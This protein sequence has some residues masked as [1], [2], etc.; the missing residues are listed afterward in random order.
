VCGQSNQIRHEKEEAIEI[1]ITFPGGKKV[2]A[3]FHNFTV[4]TDQSV[5][6][7]GEGSAPSP[8]EYFLAS[9][10]TCAGIYVLS[11]CENRKIPTGHISL[12]Q[13]LEYR[14]IDEGK[15]V[16]DK[17]VID[18]IVPPTFPEKYHQA[19]MKVADQC[20]VKKTIMNP[21]NFEIR[22]IVQ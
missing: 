9:I 5:K 20:A 11:F 15:V 1:K 8:Y 13:R 6:D 12:E 22:T 2:N 19:L 4:K 14:K 7:G 17:I 3:E 10:G 16:L 21:P 18:I